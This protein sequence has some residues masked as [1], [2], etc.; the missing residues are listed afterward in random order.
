[1]T[2]LARA[3][4]PHALDA[5][6]LGKRR[7]AAVAAHAVTRPG[8]AGLRSLSR[9]PTRSFIYENLGRALP[10]GLKVEIRPSSPNFE[11]GN[12]APG[13]ALKAQRRNLAENSCGRPLCPLLQS[14]SRAV[15]RDTPNACPLCGMRRRLLSSR[16]RGCVWASR[17]GDG[18]G[19][20]SRP[21][22]DGLPCRGTP[23]PAERWSVPATR[24]AS[25]RG[26]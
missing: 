20:G 3:P 9:R 7:L 10:E 26:P 5:C 17:Q 21:L 6:F 4:A 13:L 2:S 8:R 19:C 1:M 15:P 11:L 23:S 12:F 18:Q 14:P 24:P 22:T 16:S 25:G